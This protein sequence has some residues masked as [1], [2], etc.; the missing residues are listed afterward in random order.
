M[1]ARFIRF[2]EIEID[3][4]R[5][6]KDVVVENGVVRNRDKTASRQHK[7]AYGHTPLSANESIPWECSRLLVGTGANGRLPITPEVQAAARERG[8]ELIA[9]PTEQACGMLREA[10]LSTTNAILHLT[11]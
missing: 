9:V 2:G 4:T 7:A 3:G 10:D 11:C 1:K 8:V 6:N 5:Y